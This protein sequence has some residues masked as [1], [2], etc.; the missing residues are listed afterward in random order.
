MADCQA[1]AHTFASWGGAVVPA[2]VMQDQGSWSKASIRGWPRLA[3]SDPS[4][5]RPDWFTW[6]GSWWV[7]CCPRVGGLVCMDLDGPEAIEVAR[8]AIKSGDLPWTGEELVYTTPGHGGGM[9][10]WWRWPTSLAPFSRLV[11]TLPGGAEVDLRGEAGF[12]LLYGAPRPDLPEGA[13]YELR[14]RPGEGGPPPAP[15]GLRAWVES[16]GPSRAEDAPVHQGRQLSPEG[17]ARLAAKQGGRITRDRH[18][19]LFRVCSWLRVRREFNT[20]EA[21]ATELWRLV[22]TYFDCGNE[23]AEHWQREAIRVARNARRYMEE[24]DRAQAEAAAA[25]LAALGLGPQKN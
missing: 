9:H 24:R 15:D 18:S 25:T 4:M 12:V 23:G 19:T 10:I 14:S 21:L 1:L 16:L 6:G 11:A 13:K 20:F 3:S 22:E 8:S 5:W 17:L 2:R 7:A